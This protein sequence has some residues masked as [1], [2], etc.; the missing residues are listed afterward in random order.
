M[1]RLIQ[2]VRHALRMFVRSPIFTLTAVGALALGIAANAA[3]FSV[4]NAVV[5][6][7]LPYP[8]ADRVVMFQTAGPQGANSGG[9][10]AKFNF[11]RQQTSVL[12]QVSAYRYGTFNLTGITEP[13]QVQYGQ[14][15]V[16]F[17]RVFGIPI[18]QG[19]GFLPEEDRPG[20]R[21]VAVL[22]HELWER[23]FGLDPAIIGKTVMLGSVSHEVV[24]IV[25][26][27]YRTEANPPA[28]LWTPFQLDPNATDQGHF[29]NVVGRL[30][31]DVT[32]DGAKAALAVAT[33]DFRRTFP[34]ALGKEAKFAVTPMRETLIGNVRNSL[35]VLA[36]AVGFVLLIACANVANLLLVRATTRRREMA[37]R[38]SIG[39]GRGRIIR[40][41]LTESIVLAVVGGA[42]GM[43]LGSLGIRALL[44]VNPTE[45]PRLGPNAMYV[46]LDWRVALFTLGVTAVTGLLFGLVPAIQASRADLNSALKEAGGRSGSGFRHNKARATLVVVEVA[47]ALVLLVGAALLGRSF[48]KLRSVQPGFDTHNILTMRMSLAD[49]RFQKA[50]AVAR[51]TA[52]GVERLRAI[53]GVEVASASCCVPLE[54]GYGLPFIVAGRPL[55]GPS[56]GGGRWT[57]IAPGYFD[58]FRIPLLRGRAFADGDRAGAPLVVIINQAMAK[59]FW[60]DGQDPMAD[61]LI[62]GRG[63][64]LEFD[65]P[66]RQIVGIVGD[67]RDTGLNREPGPVMYVPTAQINDG[68]NALNVRVSPLV[69]LLRTHV[70]PYSVRVAAQTQ[71]RD[72]SGGL[73]VGV[74]RSM[75]ET[76]ARSTAAADFMTLL[77]TVFGSAALLLAAI[78]LYGLVA[79]SVQQQT[80]EIGIRLALG[81]PVATVRNRVVAHGMRLA[82][83]GVVAGLGLSWAMAKV[84]ASLLFNVTPRDPVVFVAVPAVLT[85]IALIGSWIP[86]RTAARV[87]PMIALRAD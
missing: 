81:S 16:E 15:S 57:T 3:I 68:V 8:D 19:R 26:K 78:G 85:F 58:V 83:I 39:A 1:D 47:L 13:E 32:V 84:M 54:G 29:F 25:A 62:I 72:I 9:S 43:V 6:R 77:L 69:W 63:V 27:G 45:I 2:D 18:T 31:P 49:P 80:Q 65:E 87:D 20:G 41:L 28:E 51:L 42:V 14:V 21:K 22:T 52:D 82:A 4:I 5:L 48:L 40:Q 67:T 73:P 76:L 33:E 64:G 34:N 44:S 66:P 59:Q 60:K 12:Q 75:E 86:A 30:N 23:R 61:Q 38:A 24:G 71:L 56:H 79:Y 17:F 70:E 74:V 53:P 36:G 50:E 10:P 55:E 35:Y 7:P 46:G 11:W 37:I